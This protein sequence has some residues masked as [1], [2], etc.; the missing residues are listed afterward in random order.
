MKVAVLVKEVPE[1]SARTRIDSGTLRLDRSG[2]AALNP[3]DAHALEEALQIRERDGDCE[4]VAI[5][6]A[7]AG[8]ADSLRKPCPFHFNISAAGAAPATPGAITCACRRPRR[9]RTR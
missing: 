1:A 8:A 7:P 6:M 9:S 2:A 4:V 5:M 3:F